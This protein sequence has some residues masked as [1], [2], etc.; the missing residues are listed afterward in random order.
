MTEWTE[1]KRRTMRRA[2]LAGGVGTLIEYYDFSL[3]GYLAV[4]IA[5]LFF[6]SG[7]PVV[8]LL[9][10]LA[11][12][13]TGYLIR[14]IGGVFFG[15][16]GDRFGRRRALLVT[17]LSMGTSSTLLGILPTHAQ[18]GLA[19]TVLLIVIRMLQGFSAG[20]EVGGSATVIAESTP[21]RLKATYGAFTPFGATGGFALAAAVAGLVSGLTTHEQMIS[22]GWRL[23]FLLALPLTL[24]CLWIR[25]RVAETHGTTARRTG[26]PLVALLRKPAPLVQASLVSLGVNGTAYV[27]LTYLSIHLIQRLHYPPT[28]VY[29]LATAAIGITTLTI[30]F[31]G[32]LG[33]R[34]GPV[35]LYALGSAGFVVLAYPAIAVM[36]KGLGIAAI[37]YVVFQLSSA[38]TQVG[39]YTVLPQL[40]GPDTRYTGVATGWN[41]G[42]VIGGG[43]APFLAVWLIQRTGNV[44]A[45]A[46]FVIANAVIGL[47]VAFWIHRSGRVSSGP[48]RTDG[49]RAVHS[50]IPG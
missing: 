32:R 46:W 36:G 8:S 9:A 42:V 14:P 27:G 28:P 1:E 45:P 26:S 3:Y 34:I 33:D 23:P 12:F 38:A 40:F 29:W 49:V 50:E 6:P 21:A 48:A 7:D 18:A 2:A 37:A 41:I 43:S 16:L 4:V 31:A 10:S 11:V 17:L 39:A 24:F 47:A 44:L 22:W 5:P 25:T 19:A 35:R 13:A 20:G 30:P 15:Y